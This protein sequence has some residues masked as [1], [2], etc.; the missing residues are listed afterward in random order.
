MKRSRQTQTFDIAP[1]D[2][3]NSKY[4]LFDMWLLYEK[5]SLLK[6]IKKIPTTYSK[7]LLIVEKDF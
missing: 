6:S 4:I 7:N 1:L 3:S 2:I 5:N